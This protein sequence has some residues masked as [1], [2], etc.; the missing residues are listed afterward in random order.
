MCVQHR[1]QHRG[2]RPI[3]EGFRS[4]HDLLPRSN[5]SGASGGD[6]VNIFGSP[7]WTTSRSN[8]YVDWDEDS[9]TFWNQV[10]AVALGSWVNGPGRD[11][12]HFTHYS[13]L[14]TWEAAWGL[15]PVGPGDR[16]AAPMLGAFNLRPDAGSAGRMV[17][18][19][20]AHPEVYARGEAQVPSAGA[21]DR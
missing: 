11:G 10:A 15:A 2:V 6:P 16:A 8:A 17:R 5:A 19:P 13:L 1:R 14:R 21:P 12:A 20:S 18:L 4:L 9:G 7:A 3:L